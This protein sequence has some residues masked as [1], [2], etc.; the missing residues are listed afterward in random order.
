LSELLEDFSVRKDKNKPALNDDELMSLQWEG[1]P[2]KLS[3][4]LANNPSRSIVIGVRMPTANPA[5]VA[6]VWKLLQIRLVASLQ[7]ANIV[8]PLFPDHPNDHASVS[9]KVSFLAQLYVTVSSYFHANPDRNTTETQIDTILKAIGPRLNSGANVIVF[10]RHPSNFEG[11]FPDL[12]TKISTELNN[13]KRAKGR[14]MLVVEDNDDTVAFI[15]QRYDTLDLDTFTISREEFQ[16]LRDE[17]GEM[18]NL[19]TGYPVQ[20]DE[21]E[22]RIFQDQSS[23]TPMQL[24]LSL[25]EIVQNLASV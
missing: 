8:L 17:K 16:I 23:V 2:Q 9:N 14:L 11:D 12:W 13:V 18:P 15:Q 19:I 10:S 4:I 1:L 6:L 7:S 20:V 22:A 21:L 24:I 3:E 25:L 5:P